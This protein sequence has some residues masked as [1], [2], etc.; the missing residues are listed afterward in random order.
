MHCW[1]EMFQGDS[2]SAILP[3]CCGWGAEIEVEIKGQVAALKCLAH[4]RGSTS[5]N[6]KRQMCGKEQSQEG[7]WAEGLGERV[8]AV[9]QQWE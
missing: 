4:V 8:Q 9:P 3:F 6:E 1:E 2:S 5:R 7:L